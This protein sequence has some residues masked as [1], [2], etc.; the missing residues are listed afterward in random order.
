MTQRGCSGNISL[1]LDDISEKIS[2]ILEEEKIEMLVDVI[3][4]EPR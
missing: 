4:S 2:L 1:R 3:F